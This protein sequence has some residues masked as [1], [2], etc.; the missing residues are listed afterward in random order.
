MQG[1]QPHTYNKTKSKYWNSLVTSCSACVLCV[2]MCVCKGMRVWV[3]MSYLPLSLHLALSVS[4]FV[5]ARVLL[6]NPQWS[7][8]GDSP[9]SDSWMLG[10]IAWTTTASFNNQVST[11]LPVLTR[12]SITL[13]LIHLTFP[14]RPYQN[15]DSLSSYPEV[16][17]LY[18]LPR[19]HQSK[20]KLFSFCYFTIGVFRYLGWL[21]C[22]CTG[23]M[24]TVLRQ[25][26]GIFKISHYIYE[27]CLC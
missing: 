2:W 27:I 23:E 26:F 14:D 24:H 21:T 16:T 6:H 9:A 5:S 7:P 8:T 3:C 20:G 25:G 13:C 12:N 17:C 4:F 1:K 19:G 10:W 22:K 11:R 15:W 18:A